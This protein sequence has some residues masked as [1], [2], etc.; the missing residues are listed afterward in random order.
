[1]KGRA[2]AT[3]GFRGAVVPMVSFVKF[4]DYYG[5][6]LLLERTISQMPIDTQWAWRIYFFSLP[7]S[8][9]EMART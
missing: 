3:T 4:F 6:Y 5:Q 9:F 2:G 1:M 7:P 8:T